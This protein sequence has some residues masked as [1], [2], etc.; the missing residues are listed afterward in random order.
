[1]SRVAVL[2]LGLLPGLA[3]GVLPGVLGGL[4]GCVRAGHRAAPAPQTHALDAAGS[5]FYVTTRGRAGALQPFLL[6]VPPRAQA[7]VLLFAGGQGDIGLLPDGTLR[8]ADNLLVR[9]RERFEEQGLAVAVM[10]PPTDRDVLTGFRTAPEHT[11]D[12]A[13][14]IAYL[15]Q[16]LQ[17]PV[18]LVGTSRGTVSAAYAAS[19]L[20][21]PAGPDGVVLASSVTEAYGGAT[22]DSAELEAIRVPVLLVHNR[23]DGCPASPLTGAEAM[24]RRLVHARA[25]EL[26]VIAGGGP[27]RG[28]PCTAFNYHGFVG[29]EGETVRA[30]AD[31][32]KAHRPASG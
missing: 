8:R 32:I 20:A 3:L 16:R 11:Q 25:R 9:S 29:R 5:R 27:P 4:T 19:R 23:Q 1:M 30:M 22:A 18:W 2:L 17:V 28:A 31:W 24:L 13:G 26:I 21:P 10:A 14:V 12:I 7:V 15:R 6:L